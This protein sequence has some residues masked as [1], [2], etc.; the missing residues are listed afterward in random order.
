MKHSCIHYFAT[1]GAVKQGGAN[2]NGKEYYTNG[3]IPNFQRI[4]ML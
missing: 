4:R 3:L 1:A 2:I